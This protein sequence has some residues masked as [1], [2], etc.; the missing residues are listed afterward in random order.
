MEQE[1]MINQIINFVQQHH[2][3]TASRAVYRRM[4]GS[5][6]GAFNR[7][8]LSELRNSLETANPEEIESL[9]YIIK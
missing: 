9:Y 1:N 7:N 5:Y 8:A 3:S 2:E 4:L 6:P